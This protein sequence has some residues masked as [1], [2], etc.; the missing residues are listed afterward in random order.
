[1]K[2][3]KSIPVIGILA[4]LQLANT[5][6]LAVTENPYNG[7]WE[8]GPGLGFGYSNYFHSTDAHHSSVRN[9]KNDSVNKSYVNPG[10]WSEAKYWKLPPTGLEYYYG[11]D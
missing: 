10:E 2:R 4:F 6:V 1:M 7:I 11:F 3:D 9:P 8:Y 5:A